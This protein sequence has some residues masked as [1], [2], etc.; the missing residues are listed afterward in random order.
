LFGVVKAPA[1]H[2]PFLFQALQNPNATMKTKMIALISWAVFLASATLE[3]VMDIDFPLTPT[4][5]LAIAMCALMAA[6]THAAT[7]NSW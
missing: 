3:Y 6:T 4:A 7:T 5:W 1:T 2:T